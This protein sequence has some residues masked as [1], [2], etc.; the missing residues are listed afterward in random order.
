M[1][2][3]SMNSLEGL[4]GENKR[5]LQKLGQMKCVLHNLPLWEISIITK[6][7]ISIYGKKF[8][9]LEFPV[10]LELTSYLGGR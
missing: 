8:E 3:S 1:F 2:Y 7:N 10:N 5:G 9:N 6:R 4:V